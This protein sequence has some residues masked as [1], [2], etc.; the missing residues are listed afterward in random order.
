MNQIPWIQRTFP[1][2]LPQSLFLNILERLRG[3]PARLEERISQL[4]PEILTRRQGNSWSIQ[5]T[6]GHLLQLEP[7]WQGRLDDFAASLVTL[8]PA[9]MTNQAT[10]AAD[11]NSH[12]LADILSD[13]RRNR[14]S[15]I[16]RLENLDEMTLDR[17]AL[18]PRLQLPMRVLDMMV[19]IA[20]HDDHHLAGISALI[21]LA[22]NGH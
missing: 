21:K 13:F 11:Y 9:D 8:R 3:T 10:Y 14:M 7:L 4:T 22:G 6:A 1:T 19:F 18:H 15:M 5:E 12:A 17:T 20:E 2:N 16:I